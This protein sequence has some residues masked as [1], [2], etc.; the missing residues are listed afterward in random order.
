MW[1]TVMCRRQQ[2]PGK[3]FIRALTTYLTYLGSIRVFVAGTSEVFYSTLVL[4]GL[5]SREA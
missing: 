4:V 5:R 2:G 3:L 1:A